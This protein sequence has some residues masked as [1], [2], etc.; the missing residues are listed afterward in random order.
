MGGPRNE[1]GLRQF[2]TITGAGMS[3]HKFGRAADVII[4]GMSSEEVRKLIKNNF[5]ELKALGLTT[6]EKDTPTWCH[7]D[8]RFTG[9]DELLEV[10]FQ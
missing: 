1:S 10:A 6:I 3:Q 2:G 9:Q 4:S 7:F 8:C 5:T